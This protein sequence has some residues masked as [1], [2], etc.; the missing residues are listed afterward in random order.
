M[1]IEN[2]H[3]Q[4]TATGRWSW[5]ILKKIFYLSQGDKIKGLIFCVFRP[6]RTGV[7][8]ERVLMSYPKVHPF[9]QIY[10]TDS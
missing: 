9:G 10:E 6:R 3:E 8:T 4:G 7:Q 2:N 5:I 1:K